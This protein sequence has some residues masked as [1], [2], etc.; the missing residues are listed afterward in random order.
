MYRIF[1]R[2]LDLV[3]SAI[4]LIVLFPLFLVL[5]LILRFTAEGEVFY[6][7]KRIG[8]KNKIFDLLLS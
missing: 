7:Q 3:L 5:L 1:K 8:F 2:L 4:G 6:F